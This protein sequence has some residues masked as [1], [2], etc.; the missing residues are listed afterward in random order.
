MADAQ[1]R[2]EVVTDHK[3]LIY[4]STTCTLNRSH[5]RSSTFLA[6]YDFEIVFRP[7]GQHGK[8]DALSRQAN[9]AHRPRDATYPQQS[10]CLVKP[11]QLQLF[12]TC[13]LQDD[14]LLQQIT[15]ASRPMRLP[16]RFEVICK[17]P[18]WESKGRTLTSSPYKMVCSSE[19]IFYTS[20]RTHVAPG[21]CGKC[22]N[23]PL[24]SHFGVAKALE[25]IS[26][27]Y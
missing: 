6:D 4:F 24:A 23:D 19:I 9:L 22:H 16:S 25:L 1:H 17:T 15:D 18:P 3:N 26:R 11:D 20:Q 10:R 8:D 21:C 27:G 5:A 13:M 7:S 2:I 14:L 12:S